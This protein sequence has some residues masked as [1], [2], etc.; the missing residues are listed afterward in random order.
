LIDNSSKNEET[1]SVVLNN[2]IRDEL[3]FFINSCKKNQV[4]SPPYPNATIA[5]S[6]LEVVLAAEIE[7]SDKK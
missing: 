5:K 4:I 7:N 3:E 1:I 6:I 2:T